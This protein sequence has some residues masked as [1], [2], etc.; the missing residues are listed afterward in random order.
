MTKKTATLGLLVLLIGVIGCK[1]EMVGAPCIPET[2]N[3]SVNLGINGTTWSIETGSV[4]CA[5]H[6]CLTQINKST[7]VSGSRTEACKKDPTLKNC[8]MEKDNAGTIKEGP[9]Q[10]KFSFC[11]CRCADPEGH[12]YKDDHDK[13]SDLC[14]CPPSTVC[15]EVLDPI[16][17]ISDK[18]PGS[19]CVPNCIDE[20][21][22]TTNGEEICTPAKDSKKPWEWTCEKTP[23]GL[24]GKK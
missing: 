14:E 19:Y 11:S 1:E 20:P 21:C 16:E 22:D 6:L 5:T 17:G 8:W 2:D 7:N 13:Y 12:M 10:L 23:D 24:K 18:L 4:Q 9:V 15:K 3:G